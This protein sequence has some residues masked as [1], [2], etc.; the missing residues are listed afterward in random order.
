MSLLLNDEQRQLADSAQAFLAERSPASLQ[1][2]LRDRDT[3]LGF[4]PALWK[5]VTE[6][7][8]TAAVFPESRGGLDFGWQ[9]FGAVFEAVGR[10]LA[11][12]PLLSSVVLAGQLVLRLGDEAQCE[13]WLPSIMDGSARFALALEE[14]GRHDPLAINTRARK[15]D[16]T[17]ILDGEKCFVID[18]VDA[19]WLIVVA[20]SGEASGVAEG[21]SLFVVDAAAGG[22]S[23]TRSRMADS[24]NSARVT[25]QNVRVG[26]DALLGKAGEAFTELE[27]VLDRARVCL[28]AEALGLLREVFQRTIDYLKERVQFDVK[29]GSFQALQHRAAR[30]YCDLELLESTVRAGFE[31]IDS[32]ADELPVLAS[33]A[34]AQAA[35]LCVQV[36]NEAIQ[37]HG[38]IGVT[39]ELDLGLFVKRARVVQQTLG[40]GVFHRHRYACLRGF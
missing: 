13:R 27:N 17:W 9:G 28:A 31:A 26:E 25:L 10:N 22:V 40:D 21:L 33:L 6:M 32:G 15:Q 20:R 11:A 12:L 30:L 35:D 38:G 18:G 37:L 39:D 7:G 14:N 29:I 19:G 4:E 8:W 34:K 3:D 1:R 23:V 36:A 5:E 16:G 2:A 24:R